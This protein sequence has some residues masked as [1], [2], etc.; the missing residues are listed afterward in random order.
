MILNM[1]VLPE[2]RMGYS[3]SILSVGMVRDRQRNPGGRHPQSL[4]TYRWLRVNDGTIQGHYGGSHRGTFMARPG[5]HFF[6][7]PGQDVLWEHSPG[8]CYTY[9]DFLVVPSCLIPG[10][11]PSWMLAE[12]VAQPTPQA[13]WGYPLRSQVPAGA[14]R[15]RLN[16]Q[17]EQI[18][19][20]WSQ[21]EDGRRMAHAQ[22]ALALAVA[23][24]ELRPA[25]HHPELV[26]EQSEQTWRQQAI[27]VIHNHLADPG[28]TVAHLAQLCGCS[29]SQ[30]HRRLCSET[31]GTPPGVLLRTLRLK[32]ACRL[33][34]QTQLSVSHIARKVGY[35]NS[36]N[37][38]TT[39]RRCQGMS[40]QQ[41]RKSAH[42]T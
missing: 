42:G 18:H 8:L 14:G 32:A 11:E 28:F 17:L 37:F 33:L 4:A 21:G 26:R 7:F 24:P 2:M 5:E 27:K 34:Q 16:Q 39:F 20:Q 10:A 13:L 19:A 15:D 12:T 35:E 40:P 30:L 31:G 29:A 3:P 25:E 36:R 6:W 1:D 23:L 9:C 22:L 38:S 41:Y